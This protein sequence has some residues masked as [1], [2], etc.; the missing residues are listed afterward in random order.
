MERELKKKLYNNALLAERLSKL[1]PSEKQIIIKEL[2]VNKSERQL[3][4]ELGI[5]RSTLNDWKTL[6]QSN[7]GADVHVS[8]N[9][10]IRKLE[11][12][13]PKTK[14]EFELLSRIYHL[15]KSKLVIK[16]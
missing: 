8:L 13:T 2:T 4:L 10:I 7:K 14:E 12:F 6:R 16:G 3:A 11:G 1:S 9:S 15:V 5:S